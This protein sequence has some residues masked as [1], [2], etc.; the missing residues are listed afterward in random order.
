[1]LLEQCLNGLTKSPSS[2]DSESY[3]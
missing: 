2:E 3:Q 1:M